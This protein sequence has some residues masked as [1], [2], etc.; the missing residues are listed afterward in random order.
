ML[1]GTGDVRQWVTIPAG[2]KE[3]N[4]KLN[5][6][7]QAVQDFC[8]S[9]THRELEAARY[10]SDPQYSFLDGRGKA[11][12]YVPQYPVSYV[13]GAYV[14]SDREFGTA[15]MID[16]GDIFFYPDGKIISE[17]GYFIRG[18]RNVKIDY[19]AGYAPI[20]GGTHDAAVSSYPLPYDL[21]QT[22][23]E[24]VVDAFKEGVTAIHSVVSG[25]ET[26][27]IRMFSGKTA[28]KMT[29]DRYKRMDMGL[30]FRDE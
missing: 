7:C 26:K 10:N 8:N 2:D 19:I 17:G 28:W 4:P 14:D 27:F 1:I 3:P 9:Y 22:M 29:L 23:V 5:S 20:V 21:K 25:E 24:M 11:W 15:T 30:G 12:I 18:R 13:F 16:A 6:L